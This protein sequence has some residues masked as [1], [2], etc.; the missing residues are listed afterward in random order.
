MTRNMPRPTLL[1]GAAPRVAAR[2]RGANQTTRGTRTV[3]PCPIRARRGAGDFIGDF[4]E[5]EPS[6]GSPFPSSACDAGAV[7]VVAAQGVVPEQLPPRALRDAR[8]LQD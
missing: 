2:P 5:G 4:I 6:Q 7:A 8:P 3:T 1:P